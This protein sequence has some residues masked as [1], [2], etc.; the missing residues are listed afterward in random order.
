MNGTRMPE[1]YDYNNPSTEYDITDQNQPTS[2]RFTVEV[3][4]VHHGSGLTT[5]CLG[6]VSSSA[7][8]Y[9]HTLVTSF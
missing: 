3:A 6:L 9:N 7:S 2:Q 4:S 8:R 1:D 5:N